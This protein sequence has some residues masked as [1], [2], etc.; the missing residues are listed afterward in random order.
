MADLDH[1]LLLA[2]K[3]WKL[4]EVRRF[5]GARL[6]NTIEFDHFRALN[7]LDRAGGGLAVGELARVL[8]VDSSTASRLVD[9]MESRGYIYRAE[10]AGDRR[11]STVNL[12]ASGWTALATLQSVRIEAL[13]DITREWRAAD[14]ALLA[15]LL[16]RLN[17]AARGLSAPENEAKQ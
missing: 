9:R 13:D 15:T 4:P 16:A 7:A 17:E 3:L 11:R 6:D 8:H 14:I 10:D 1:A 2:R 5:L 12:S